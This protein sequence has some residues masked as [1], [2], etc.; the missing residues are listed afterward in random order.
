M[1][2]VEEL[3]SATAVTM[4]IKDEEAKRRAREELASGLMQRWGANIEAQLGDG[5]FVGG[6]TLNVV[7]LKLFVALRFYTGGGV[8]YSGD[9]FAAFPKLTGLLLAVKDH[10]KVVA[11]YAA[12][13]AA[14]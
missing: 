4:G 9:V 11:Y 10:P 7:D 6:A 3:R 1:A 5:P 8:D 2:A 13:R 12:R 14:S